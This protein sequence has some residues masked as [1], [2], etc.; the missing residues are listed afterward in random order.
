MYSI[1]DNYTV[2]IRKG[3]RSTVSP[4]TQSF[5]ITTSFARGIIIL[6]LKDSR[7]AKKHDDAIVT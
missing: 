2:I 7:Q 3:R 6:D 4:C 5:L 1:L